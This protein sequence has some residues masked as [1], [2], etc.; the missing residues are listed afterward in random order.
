MYQMRCTRPEVEARCKRLSCVH[1]KVCK[2]LGTDHGPLVD[3][4]RKSREVPGIDRVYVASGIRMDL[5]QSSPEYLAELVKHHV[6]GHLKVAPEHT[7][8][9]VLR[10]MKKPDVDDFQGFARAFQQ[11]SARAGKKQYL[12]PYFIASHPGSDINAMIDLAVFLKRNGYR[13]D[14]VQDFIPAPFDIA[15]CMYHTGLDPFTGEEVH[16]AQNLRDRKMQRAL[17]QFF[18]PE[19]Y[20][21]VREALL[22]AGRGDLIGN[23]CDCLIPAQPLKAAIEARRQRAN[24]VAEGDHYHSIANPAKGEPVGERGLP[25]QGYRPGRKTARRQDKRRE[26]KGGQSGLRS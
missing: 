4:L 11:A 15:T 9:A 8:P 1:P 5:A 22:K 18:K 24:A 23:G 25:N 14:Q 6:G 17:M 12:V 19:N 13:P 7:D 16:I 2:L 26:R 21:L 3:L 20:F 10:L